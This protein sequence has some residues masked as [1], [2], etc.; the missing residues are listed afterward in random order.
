MSAR[1]TKRDFGAGPNGTLRDLEHAAAAPEDAAAPQEIATEAAPSGADDATA[2]E[3]K[4]GA[5]LKLDPYRFQ[6]DAVPAGPGAEPSQAEPEEH[7]SDPFEDVLPPS[8]SAPRATHSTLSELG[9]SGIHRAVVPRPGLRPLA[10]VSL[11]LAAI[12]LAVLVIVAATRP[13]FRYGNVP[14]L[15]NT[16]DVVKTAPDVVKTAPDVVK[17]AQ[18]ATV[19]PSAEPVPSPGSAPRARRV[20]PAAPRETTPPQKTAAPKS[21]TPA[22]GARIHPRVDVET[23]LMP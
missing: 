16:A 2:A 13:R 18:S 19:A 17:T 9:D 6:A 21:N 15:P 10:L 1:D 14:D 23:P 4:T 12:A 20:T 3:E 22:H 8:R 11:S 7:P 5:R